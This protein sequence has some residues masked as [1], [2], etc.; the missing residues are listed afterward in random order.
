MKTKKLFVAMAVSIAAVFGFTA[1]ING[2][3]GNSYNYNFVSPAV[4][5][6]DM[7]AGLTLNTFYGPLVPDNA[8]APSLSS[9]PTGSCIYMSF[10]YNSEYQ[11]GSNAVAS[12]IRYVPVTVDYIQNEDMAM[13]NNFTCPLSSVG[14]LIDGANYTSTSTYYQG[15]FFVATY[16]K[17]G[18]NQALEYYPYI[19]PDEPLDANRVMNIYLQANIPGGTLTGTQDVGTVYGL[20]LRNML[21]SFGRDTTIN[22]NGTNYSLKYLKINL[23]YCSAIENGSPVFTSVTTQPINIYILRDDL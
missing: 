7:Q 4:I 22:D 20:D 16:A 11:T 5:G 3:G 2:N 14:L 6:S 19:K 8:S 18:Q 1:C 12:N 10:D 9:L 15:R 21:Y 13:V 17:L 23:Q